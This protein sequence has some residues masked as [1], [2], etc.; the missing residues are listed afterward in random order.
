MYVYHTHTREILSIGVYD[1]PSSLVWGSEYEYIVG[2]ILTSLTIYL[3]LL[4]LLVSL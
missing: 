4:P 2:H 3:L 1:E